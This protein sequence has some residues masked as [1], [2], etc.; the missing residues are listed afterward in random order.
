M[1]IFIV[2]LPIASPHRAAWGPD[3]GRRFRDVDPSGVK[4][5]TPLAD[6]GSRGFDLIGRASTISCDFRQSCYQIWPRARRVAPPGE[7]PHWNARIATAKRCL[8]SCYAEGV[9]ETPMANPGRS[10][11]LDLGGVYAGRVADG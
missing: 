4:G 7:L 1:V 2:A 3:T 11:V 5:H 10:I 6:R 8:L 9:R